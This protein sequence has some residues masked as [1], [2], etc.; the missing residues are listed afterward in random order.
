MHGQKMLKPGAEYYVQYNGDRHSKASAHDEV[1][2]YLFVQSQGAPEQLVRAEEVEVLG[3]HLD[4][5][6]AARDLNAGAPSPSDLPL[7]GSLQGLLDLGLNDQM[8]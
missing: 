4:V 6:V 8:V 5:T 3:N 7:C 1:L 2:A